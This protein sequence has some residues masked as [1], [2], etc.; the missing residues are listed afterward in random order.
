MAAL[1]PLTAAESARL[2][3]ECEVRCWG[4]RVRQLARQLLAL[5]RSYEVRYRL[6]STGPPTAASSGLLALAGV[7][8]HSLMD[9]HVLQVT[10]V[11]PA[12]LAHQVVGGASAVHVD[13]YLV[14]LDQRDLL[15]AP[16]SPAQLRAHVQRLA[17]QTPVAVTET[18]LVLRFVRLERLVPADHARP[19][20]LVLES[21]RR[22]LAQHAD[23]VAGYAA[24]LERNRAVVTRELAREKK[25]L[26]YVRILAAETQQTVLKD[27]KFL[28][29]YN[30]QQWFT[31]LD[32]L[33][34]DD[35]DDDDVNEDDETDAQTG[36]SIDETGVGDNG[37]GDI[38]DDAVDYFEIEI[39][40]DDEDEQQQR[41]RGVPNDY[42]LV[43]LTAD[44]HA[45]QPPRHNR[46]AQQPAAA[47]TA[48]GAAAQQ[49]P[50]GRSAVAGSSQRGVPAPAEKPAR[51]PQVVRDIDMSWV[52]TFA[53]ADLKWLPQAQALLR[54]F[55]SGVIDSFEQ[56][57]AGAAHPRVVTTAMSIAEQLVRLYIRKRYSQSIV[58]TALHKEFARHVRMLRSNLS[59]PKSGKLRA[60]LL[61]GAVTTA[62]L[63]EMTVDELAPEALRLERERRYEQHAQ[64]SMIKTPTGPTLVK[65]KH[66]YKEVNFGGLTGSQD[67]DVQTSDTPAPREAAESSTSGV[68]ASEEPAAMDVEMTAAPFEYKEPTGDATDVSRVQPQ[69]G[70]TPR[71]QQPPATRA[72][73]GA[74]SNGSGVAN[75][76][77][78]GVEIQCPAPTAAAPAAPGKPVAKKRVSFASVI[79]I[80][81]PP[82]NIESEASRREAKA[83]RRE[84]AAKSEKRK[85]RSRTR[86]VD[87]KAGRDFLLTL[88]DPAYDL[89]ESLRMF[90]EMLKDAPLASMSREFV[91]TTDVKVRCMMCCDE[92]A[93]DSS[94]LTHW[95]LTL[96]SFSATRVGTTIS[97]TLL[98]CSWRILS[99]KARATTNAARTSTLRTS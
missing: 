86:S 44:T 35:D 61:D 73:N 84:A 66:G 65:T 64:S 67:S 46:A 24:L 37:G 87:V 70:P 1:A 11:G 88:L 97:C 17:Q 29:A 83:T 21:L 90:I 51:K 79:E 34:D 80:S 8:V 27:D 18:I 63:C 59:N 95:H 23:L 71:Q 19:H 7:D 81:A 55:I 3:L 10:A 62:R 53:K 92:V 31:A 89:A 32:D 94:P 45:E 30:F 74:V 60:D 82:Q 20:G 14:G 96:Y 16:L 49:A 9:A 91:L 15:V 28:L 38:G 99:S 25:L 13:D 56:D 85:Q 39:S 54:N 68:I 22:I 33:Q 5:G 75:K 77:Q 2:A 12:R 26:V 41:R 42:A 36:R 6:P 72:V 58:N 48:R 98:A 47:R 50:N 43:D 40:E 93:L 69:G 76:S 4:Q 52:N 78:G 57:E